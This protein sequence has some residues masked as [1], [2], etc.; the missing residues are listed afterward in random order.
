MEK[1]QFIQLVI[2]VAS[3]LYDK[4]IEGRIFPEET[5]QSQPSLPEEAVAEPTVQA[6]QKKGVMKTYRARKEH[7]RLCNIAA[8]YGLSTEDAKGICADVGISSYSLLGRCGY[9]ANTDAL[10][11]SRV[12]EKKFNLNVKS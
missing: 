10:L 2:E 8:H 9:I 11:L 5:A 3:A 7:I 4:H 12:I 1:N 6:E